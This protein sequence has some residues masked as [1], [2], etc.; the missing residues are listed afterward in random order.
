MHNKWYDKLKFRLF[1]FFFT[2]LILCNTL[3]AQQAPQN[4]KRKIDS[5]VELGIQQKAFPGAQL[6]I[7]K[8]GQVLVH[9]SY[10]YHTYDSIIPVANT[11]LYDLAS[12]TKIL[13][14][15]LAFLFQ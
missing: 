12:V 11:H 1:L 7:Y 15:T 13:A 10:G 6:L 2:V 4:I 14:G 9:Q 5:I 3:F 8:K